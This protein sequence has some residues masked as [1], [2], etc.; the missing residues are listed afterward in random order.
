MAYTDRETFTLEE[1]GAPELHVSYVRPGMLPYKDARALFSRHKLYN[2]RRVDNGNM[3]LKEIL[4]DADNEFQWLL[5]LV[6]EWNIPKPGSSDI[7]P[8]PSVQP[9]IWDEAPGLYLSYIIKKIKSDPA[10]TNF[11]AQAVTA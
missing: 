8:V 5:S 1:V 10:G 2:I 9:T 3:T 6:V 7:L 11:L 4:E